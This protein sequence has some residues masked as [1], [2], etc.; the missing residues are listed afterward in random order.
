MGPSF[1][2]RVVGSEARAVVLPALKVTVTWPAGRPV[3]LSRA[4]T[5][6]EVV[7]A[8]G[9]SRVSRSRIGLPSAT[10]DG[11]DSDTFGVGKPGRPRSSRATKQ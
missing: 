4:R 5:R 11:A 6:T 10:S 1:P 7:R 3:T 2:S 8:V 9:E